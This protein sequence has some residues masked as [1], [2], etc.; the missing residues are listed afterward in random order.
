MRVAQI[1]QVRGNWHIQ[2][3]SSL[4]IGDP[5]DF[6]LIVFDLEPIYARP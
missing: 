2:H 5:F 4:L 3:F 1:L 6:M